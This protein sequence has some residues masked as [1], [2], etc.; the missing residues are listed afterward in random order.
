M[1]I[2]GSDQVVVQPDGVHVTLQNGTQERMSISFYR[3]GIGTDGDPGST[4][5]LVDS[6]PGDETATCETMAHT[7]GSVGLTIVDPN[8]YWTAPFGDCAVAPKRTGDVWSPTA[9]QLAA[10]PT[11]GDATDFLHGVGYGEVALAGHPE[12]PDQRVYVLRQNGAIVATA[13]YYP[14]GDGWTWDSYSAC[15]GDGGAVSGTF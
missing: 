7:V 6:S 11:L 3:A 9:E 2:V 13:T 1:S 14:R 10:D 4:D 5:L 12:N 8:G 15:T